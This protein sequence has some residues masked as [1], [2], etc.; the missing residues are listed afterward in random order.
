MGFRH[1]DV[2]QIILLR[3]QFANHVERM[4]THFVA[5]V[6]TGQLAINVILV[7]M[8]SIPVVFPVQLKV[9]YV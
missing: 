1:K 6:M 5:S 2:S 9:H 7:F 4:L 8:Q 3:I